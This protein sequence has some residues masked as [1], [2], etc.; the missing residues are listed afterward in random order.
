MDDLLT[1]LIAY[2]SSLTCEKKNLTPMIESCMVLKLD[3]KNSVFLLVWFKGYIELLD[4][5]FVSHIFV[6]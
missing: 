5:M 1:Y 4:Y 2:I 6:N 3:E